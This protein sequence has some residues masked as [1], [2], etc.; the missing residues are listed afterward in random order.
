MGRQIVC[1]FV[2]WVANYQM[3]RT[4]ALSDRENHFVILGVSLAK[5]IKKSL[6]RQKKL[7]SERLVIS[8]LLYFEDIFLFFLLHRY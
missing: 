8:F 3:L 6:F 5:K 2:L 1:Y 4:T 7:R